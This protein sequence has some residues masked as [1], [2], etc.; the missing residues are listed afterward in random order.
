[1]FL[2]LSKH[3]KL[4]CKYKSLFAFALCLITG[5]SGFGWAQAQNTQGNSLFFLDM[6][7]QK[8]GAPALTAD[9]RSQLETLMQNYRSEQQANMPD[10]AIREAHKNYENAVLS[11]DSAAAKA[12]ADALAAAIA[13]DMPRRL[14]AKAAF[15]VQAL[16]I[17]QPQV[18]ALR[19]EM[20]NGGLSLLLGSLARAGMPGM[21]HGMWPGMGK[22]GR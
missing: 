21:H 4:K 20:G 14:E 16:N 12:A 5:M 18:N 15:E 13:G 2:E 19:Q 17:L 8:S 10:P 1:L 9:Q 7:V 11:G 22:F 6:A 3:M